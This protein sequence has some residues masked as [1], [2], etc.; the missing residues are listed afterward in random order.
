MA[1]IVDM[2]DLPAEHISVDAIAKLGWQSEQSRVRGILRGAAMSQYMLPLI[3]WLAL[4]L[5][6]SR[7]VVS[8]WWQADE[9]RAFVALEAC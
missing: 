1:S 5:L 2:Q 6:E 8:S 4:T 9:A 7:L 3:P